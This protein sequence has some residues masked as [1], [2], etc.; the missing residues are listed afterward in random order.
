[1]HKVKSLPKFSEANIKLLLIA[2][3][4]F[5]IAFSISRSAVI[6]LAICLVTTTMAWISNRRSISK[7]SWEYLLVLQEIIDHMISGIQSG[8]S[9]SE[10]LS[11]LAERGPIV[12]QMNFRT[13]REDLQSGISFENSISNLQESLGL[14]AADQLFESL[15][16]AKNLGGSELLGMLRQLGDFTRQDLSLRQEIAAKQ[17]WIRNSAHLSAA[18]PWILLLLLSTQPSTSDAF[19][20]PQGITILAFG[21]AMTAIAYLWMGHLSVLPEPKR[22]FGKAK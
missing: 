6:A 2:S 9:L 21:V 11:N 10:S 12:T 5:L 1:M 15:I 14:R 13:F 17:G 19:Q 4:T 7:R 20:S 18:A 3:S 16:F 8:M 22:V